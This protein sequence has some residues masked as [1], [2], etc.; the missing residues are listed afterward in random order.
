MIALH[1]RVSTLTEDV[2]RTE[3]ALTR[4]L[5][6]AVD[7]DEWLRRDAQIQR[8]ID[9]MATKEDLN[10]LRAYMTELFGDHQPRK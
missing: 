5:E 7:R 1:S 4:H 10:Q 8:S 9:A 3:A 6:H 2:R